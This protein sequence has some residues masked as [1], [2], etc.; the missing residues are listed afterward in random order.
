[1]PI[2]GSQVRVAGTGAVWK[3]P[4]G[5]VLPT[6]EAAAYGTGWVNLGYVEDG[7]KI[8][9]DLKTNEVSAWQTLE[10]VRIVNQGLSRTVSFTLLQSNKDTVSLAWGGATITS[11]TGSKYTLALPSASAVGEFIIGLDWNDGVTIQ[12][13]IVQRA[14]LLSLPE[15][16]FTRKDAVKYDLEFRALPPANGTD[17]ILTYGSDANVIA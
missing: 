7:F 14:A 16:T 9:Q 10:P 15:L 1:M 12:R 3:A 8:K 5:T 13:L 2:N 11:G 4:I 17:S 6:D